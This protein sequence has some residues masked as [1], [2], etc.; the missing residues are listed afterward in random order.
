MQGEG[1]VLFINVDLTN[2]PGEISGFICKALP[3]RKL[4]RCG[5]DKEKNILQCAKKVLKMSNKAIII[6]TV[7]LWRNSGLN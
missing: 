5:H 1:A 6:L 4:Y 2:L 3:Q 7:G